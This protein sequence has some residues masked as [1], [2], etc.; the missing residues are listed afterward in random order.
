MVQTLMDNVLIPALVILGPPLA[1]FVSIQLTLLAKRAAA[2]AKIEVDA[3]QEAALRHKIRGAVLHTQQT[4]VK[5]L[6]RQK[7][8]GHL[9]PQEAIEAA[10]RT[11]SLSTRA[12]GREGLKVLARVTNKGEGALREVIEEEVG[13][14]KLIPKASESQ[15]A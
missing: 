14:M 7:A 15:P 9:T 6:R 4:F 11:F 1:T 3:T 2:K 10:G 8:D 13:A 5:E 12:L